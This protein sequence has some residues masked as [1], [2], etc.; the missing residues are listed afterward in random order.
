[1]GGLVFVSCRLYDLEVVVHKS[2]K[3][4][5]PSDYTSYLLA[6]DP[7][8]VYC[9][10]GFLQATRNMGDWYLPQRQRQEANEQ[11]EAAQYA[12]HFQRP[13]LREPVVDEICQPE[14]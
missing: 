10:Q 11:K 8:G 2:L 7:V 13:I 12:E 14:R 4:L 3:P 1:M 9:Q 6:K 5:I